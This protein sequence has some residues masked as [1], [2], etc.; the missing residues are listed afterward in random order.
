MY[1]AKWVKDNEVNSSWIVDKLNFDKE[2]PLTSEEFKRLVTLSSV[3]TKQQIQE[4]DNIDK[5]IAI[6]PREEELC[7][8]ISELVKLGQQKHIYEDDIKDL[9]SAISIDYGNRRLL[10]LVDDAIEKFE[11]FENSWLGNV[12]KDYYSNSETQGLWQQLVY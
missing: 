10:K 2:N 4:I 11:G 12:M 5:Y 1:M 8:D 3:I 7:D 6:L 9:N